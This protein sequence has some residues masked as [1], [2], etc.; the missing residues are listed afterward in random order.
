MC[1]RFTPNAVAAF[2]QR[3]RNG[4]RV[5]RDLSVNALDRDAHV[6]GISVEPC[7]FGDQAQRADLAVGARLDVDVDD[8]A[9]PNRDVATEPHAR[10]LEHATFDNVTGNVHLPPI[11]TSSPNSSRL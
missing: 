6:D 10:G 7:V 2:F 8:T 1:R 4:F 9:E 5:H 11:T 3:G